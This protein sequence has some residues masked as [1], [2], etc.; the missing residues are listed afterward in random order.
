M[1]NI[2]YYA[3]KPVFRQK[4]VCLPP[5]HVILYGLLWE[6]PV[7]CVNDVLITTDVSS[8]SRPLWSQLT[9]IARSIALW[10]ESHLVDELL[11]CRFDLTVKHV[12]YF[13]CLCPEWGRR[14]WGM[15][16]FYWLKTPPVS[17]VAQGISYERFPRPGRQLARFKPLQ[18]VHLYV[19]LI[20]FMCMIPDSNMS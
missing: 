19:P 12:F 8:A 13:F 17:S 3:M 20:D 18:W 16:D 10:L 15:S 7:S 1:L 11:N 2:V 9:G 4:T 6:K 5:I 14:V